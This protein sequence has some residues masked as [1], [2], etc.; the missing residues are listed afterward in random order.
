VEGAEFQ[1]LE[2]GFSTIKNFKPTLLMEIHSVFCMSLVCKF[3]YKLNYS[4]K[5]LEKNSPSRCFIAAEHN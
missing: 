2:G 5:I 3:L 1:V 4:W